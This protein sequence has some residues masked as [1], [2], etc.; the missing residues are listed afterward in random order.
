MCSPGAAV[1]VIRVMG[2][3]RA[4]AA[5]C[6][7][8][9]GGVM[10]F[11][12]YATDWGEGGGP[13]G[14]PRRYEEVTTFR[15]RSYTLPYSEMPGC[16]ITTTLGPLLHFRGSSPRSPLPLVMTG[17]MYPSWMS[18]RR[19]VSRMMFDISS[20]VC[21]ILR[22]MALAEWYRRSRWRSSLKTRPLYA[23]IPSNTPSP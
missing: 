23:R 5:A 14:A 2:R 9:A 15:P 13:R 18:F 12:S 6:G 20:F 17:R 1:A 16:A 7:A 8:A 21:G 3:M 19:H 4:A 10:L 11:L 22:S